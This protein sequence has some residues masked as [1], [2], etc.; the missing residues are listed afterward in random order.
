[1]DAHLNAARREAERVLSNVAQPRMGLISSFDPEKYA[2]KVRLQ[3]ENIES[4]WIP[5]AA[6]SVGAGYGLFSPGNIG[7]QV[8]VVFQEGAG[9]S[10]I[11]VGAIYNDEDHPR[12]EGL[13]GCPSGETWLV[14]KTGARIRLITDGTI[15][16]RQKAGTQVVLKPDGTVTINGPTVLVGAEGGNFLTL[17][18]QAFQSLF[19]GHTH[20]NGGPPNQQMTAS[21]LTA[22]L[23]GA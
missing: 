5:L 6:P 19:N 8:V 13:G 22:A 11:A 18:T 7:D 20:G 12:V 4:G 21:H 16:I 14:H 10:G 23:K 15:E 17:V 9:G 3:P 1:M 2:V